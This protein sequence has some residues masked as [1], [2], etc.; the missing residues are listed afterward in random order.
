MTKAEI[1]AVL[2]RVK[3]WPEAQQAYAAFCLLAIEREQSEVYELTQEER[4]D[5]EEALREEE[6][7]EFVADE[8]VEA[9]FK[10]YG[11]R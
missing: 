3:T 7:G 1:E 11:A 5:L 4:A 2:E 8:E 6:R 9:L 10:R